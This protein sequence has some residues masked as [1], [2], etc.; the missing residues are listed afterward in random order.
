MNTYKYNDGIQISTGMI[1]TK[2]KIT[3]VPGEQ[4]M[5]IQPYLQCFISLKQSETLKQR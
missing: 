4:G 5:G 2:F 3:T 1:H